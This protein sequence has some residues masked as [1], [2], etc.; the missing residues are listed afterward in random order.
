MR[1]R[2]TAK[3]KLRKAVTQERAPISASW[4]ICH[5]S[6]AHTAGTAAILVKPTLQVQPP[7]WY[8]CHFGLPAI[9]I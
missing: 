8:I 1:E 9:M 5:L 7:S 6:K 2:G 4:Y 3:A